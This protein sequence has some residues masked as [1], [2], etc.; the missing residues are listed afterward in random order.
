L[1]T[2]AVHCPRSPYHERACCDQDCDCWR[3]KRQTLVCDKC[4]AEN[5]NLA[6]EGKR[7]DQQANEV[8]GEIEPRRLYL[9]NFTRFADAAMAAY[10]AK[11]DPHALAAWVEATPNNGGTEQ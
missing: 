3:H 8:K 5:W 11:Q 7:H 10:Q 4:G 6:S 9:E 1:C 2:C